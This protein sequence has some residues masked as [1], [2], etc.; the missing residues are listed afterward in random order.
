MPPRSCLAQYVTVRPRSAAASTR[1]KLPSKTTSG[2]GDANCNT[3]QGSSPSPTS[4]LEPPPRKRCGTPWESSRL[5]RPGM[6]SCFWMRRR[7]VVPP[8]ARDV[9][10]ASEALRRSSTLSS[11]SA[12]MILASSMRMGSGML[13]P[14]QNHEFVAGAADVAGADGQDGVE[15]T[16]FAQQVLDAF[17]HGAKVEHVFVASLVNVGEHQHVGLIKGAA[18]FVPQ[19]LRARVTVRLEEHQQAIELTNARGFERG[20]DFGGVMAVIVDHGYV[21]D[22]AFNVEAP[23]DSRE[24]SEAIADQLRGHVQIKSDRCRSRGVAHVVDARRMKELENAEVVAFVSQAKFA[25]Q[26]FELDVADDEIGLAGSAVGNNRA[27]YARDHGL[28]VRRVQAQSRRALKRHATDELYEGILNVFQ[29]GILIEMLAGDGGDGGDNGREQQEAAVAFVGFDDEELALT[30]SSGGAGLIDA[31]ADDKCG[32]EM[33]RSENGSDHGGRGGFPVS[34]GH[35]DAVLEAHQFGQHFCAGD[36]RDLFLVRFDNFGVVDLDRRR[37]HY[38]VRALHVCGFV[39]FVNRGA[40]I[41]QA[42]RDVRGLGVG[43]GNGIAEREQ[44]FGD[45][46]HADAAYAH[47]M[48]ALKIAEG[49]HHRFILEQPLQSC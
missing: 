43:A 3:T 25:A 26:A 2:S 47:Q 28:H 22:R 29:R 4:R 24:S 32:I 20:A 17:L 38:H 18:E 34:A 35:G 44:H 7:S 31:A 33:R 5:S 6:D 49:D 48:N 45:A 14:Q 40:E 13:G 15:R 27:L 16:R 21:V 37:R 11:G 39:P 36:D 8:M 30:E 1:A 42:F 46:A 41:L 19:M 23:A 10:S 12:A 9:S